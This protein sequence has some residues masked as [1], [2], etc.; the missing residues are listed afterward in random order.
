MRSLNWYGNLSYGQGYSGSSLEMVKY[1]NRIMD[2][3]TIGFVDETTPKIYKRA[4]HK[5]VKEVMNKPFKLAKIGISYGLPNSFSSVM[6]KVKIGFTMFE[7]DKLP[8]GSNAWAGKTGNPIDAI[9]AMDALFVPCEHNRELFLHSG[10]KVPIFVVPLGVDTDRKP[11]LARSTRSKSGDKFRFLFVATLNERKGVD[12][13]FKAFQRVFKGRDDVELVMKVNK[14]SIK[15]EIDGVHLTIIDKYLSP[16]E[17]DEVYR[18][19][20]AFVFPSRGEGFGLT[21]LEAMYRGLPTIVSDNTGMSDYIRFDEQYCISIPMKGMS[22]AKGF[23]KEWGEVGNWFE[24]DFDAL[25]MALWDVFEN[26]NDYNEMSVKASNYV[27]QNYSY[28]NTAKR[29]DEILAEHFD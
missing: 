10:T 9:N 28:V 21:P 14:Q 26:R 16:R 15:W 24:P 4:L 2:V 19:A 1:L 29:I 22:K 17:L 11:I 20:D 12:L 6:N 23:P 5:E 27:A 3:R 13:L 18:S 7:T 25:C 8:S